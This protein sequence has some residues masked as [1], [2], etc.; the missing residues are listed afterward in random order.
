MS[1]PR[2][3]LVG[4]GPGNPDLLT[5]K[6]LRLIQG[7]EV[8][9]YDRLVPSEILDLIPPS[10]RRIFVGKE[11]RN[12]SLPQHDINLLLVDLAR[13]GKRV[14]RLKGG[15]PFIFG[16]GS[17]EALTLAEHSIPFEIVPGVTAAAGCGAYAGIPLTHRGLATGVRFVT[18]HC[19]E[20]NELVCDWRGMADPDTTLVFYMALANLDTIRRNLIA[21]GVDPAMPAA[22]VSCGTTEAQRSVL[23]TLGTLEQALARQPLPAPCLIIVGRVVAL[24]PELAWYGEREL[25]DA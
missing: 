20:D 14:V 8:V 24:A 2:V 16:R 21:A 11:T 12:H 15:D 6:A 5:V 10:A 22:A 23:A 9:V 25:A 19:R 17:E 13:E 4:A 7:A 18:G 1:T 3:H